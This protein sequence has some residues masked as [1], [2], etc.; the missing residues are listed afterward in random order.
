MDNILVISDTKQD[1]I[2]Y[3]NKV[4]LN[5]QSKVLTK[6]EKIYIVKYKRIL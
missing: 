2:Q 3:I 6:Y 1:H 4:I 5:D